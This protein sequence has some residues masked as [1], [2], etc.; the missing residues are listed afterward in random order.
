MATD[1]TV[2]A[3]SSSSLLLLSL[4]Y[5]FVATHNV[6]FVTTSLASHHST[7]VVSLV[8]K[9][10]ELQTGEF[11]VTQI[12]SSQWTLRWV[13]WFVLPL[14]YFTEAT[15]SASVTSLNCLM[16]SRRRYR[17]W[18]QAHCH[19]RLRCSPAAVSS[20]S[21]H[22]N[23]DDANTHHTRSCSEDLQSRLWVWARSIR[24]M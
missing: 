5:D 8:N 22:R 11:V 3:K 6:Q 14:F 24:R 20:E 23:D 13:S 4:H 12:E 15:T 19:C 16:P 1:L 9:L 2:Y 17:Q 18:R 7:L 21:I 10:D